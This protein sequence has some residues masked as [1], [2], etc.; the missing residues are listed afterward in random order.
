MHT[1]NQNILIIYIHIYVYNNKKF[2]RIFTCNK[3]TS[4]NQINVIAVLNRT[5]NQKHR[6][7]LVGVKTTEF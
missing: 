4:L 3:N 7:G 1:K 2:K 5:I 6:S